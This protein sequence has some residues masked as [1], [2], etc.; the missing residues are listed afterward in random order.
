MS[1]AEPT[2]KAFGRAPGRCRDLSGQQFGRLT[3][4]SPGRTAYDK[5]AWHCIC[6][7]GGR[8]LVDSRALLG[9]GSTSCGCYTRE[10][11]YKAVKRHGASRTQSYSA[12]TGMRQRCSNPNKAAYK[13]YGG[14]GIRVC[15]AWHKYE[16]F[17][18]DMGER[19]S[20]Q[21]SIDRR[22]NNKDYSPDNCRWATRTEQARNRRT[23]RMLTIFG[24]TKT[25]IEWAEDSRCCVSAQ[26]LHLRLKSGMSAEQA[27]TKPKGPY[28]RH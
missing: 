16:N 17:L 27:M 28:V 9:G 21:H 7:C 14:R 12:W 11:V 4:M 26:A 23:S 18:Q 10:Q 22:D 1:C 13:N 2:G 15:D 19:P 24:E 8:A 5:P 3:A 20:P 6:S 25:L